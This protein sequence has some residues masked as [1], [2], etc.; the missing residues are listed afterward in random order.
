M[1]GVRF[2]KIYGIWEKAH[3][4]HI[5]EKAAFLSGILISR[6]RKD[7]GQDFI[8]PQQFTKLRYMLDTGHAFSNKSL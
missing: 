3:S 8:L 5:L 6:L 1:N 4:T 2:W 7:V